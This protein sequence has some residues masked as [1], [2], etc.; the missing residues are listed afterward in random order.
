MKGVKQVWLVTN[1]SKCISEDI[2]RSTKKYGQ[3]II[4]GDDSVISYVKD[5]S[6]KY[7][8]A[9]IFL[10]KNSILIQTQFYSG[11]S[12][13]YY[14]YKN[15][16]YVSDDLRLLFSCT[17]VPFKISISNCKKF[18][19]YKC[20]IEDLQ[21]D[22]NY[23]YF[24]SVQKISANR[25]FLFKDG[26]TNIVIW[27]SVLPPNNDNNFSKESVRQI[28]RTEI[29]RTINDDIDGKFG[30]E[31]SGGVD[32]AC[33]LGE[34]ISSG[35]N[36]SNIYAFIMTFKD[37]ELYNANDIELAYELVKHFGIKAF[38]VYGDKSLRLLRHEE[39]NIC[40]INGP[41]SSANYLWLQSVNAICSELGIKYLFTGNGG[42][43][44]L[45]GSPYVYDS[46][47][48]KHPITTVRKLLS[49]SPSGQRHIRFKKLLL[50]PVILPWRY[51][52]V[53]W[54]ERFNPIPIF[55]TPEQ[56]RIEKLQ[57]VNSQSLVAKSEQLVGWGKRYIYD[58]STA[59][60]NYL[61]DY[62]DDSIFVNP[63]YCIEMCI[64]ANCLNPE[65]LYDI[66]CSNHY[67]ASKKILRDGYRGIVPDFILD[68]RIKTSYNQMSKHMFLNS[69]P[70]ILELF[71]SECYV[72]Q[73]GIINREKFVE[74]VKRLFVVCSNHSA[75]V[76]LLF[77]Y[78][79]GIIKLECW[80][81][82]VNM[83]RAYVLNKSAV[84]NTDCLLCEVE[85]F[86]ASK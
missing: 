23:S 5:N 10:S 53:L 27:K 51:Y 69:V 18:A 32:S 79:W 22:D 45:G 78:I 33:I 38:T 84:H 48:Y 50:E 83:G 13:Y 36:P 64:F 71:S 72:E 66:D 15:E 73:M 24:H 30:I 37:K 8:Y 25:Q 21:P 85:P 56:S 19:S 6:Y 49:N 43:E 29:A 14:Q 59:I 81:K 55:F 74:E 11:T 58:F 61:S 17:A 47:F 16:I 26:Q 20:Q 44:I 39:M 9:G 28:I 41:V 68:K 52:D 62:F 82:F 54:R 7:T 67:R 57:R 34:L 70:Q 42:D 77:R 4:C 2:E 12:I 46:L 1:D 35:I 65:E 80:L 75:H 3:W 31:L 63:I 40:N 86:E 60:P 76:G